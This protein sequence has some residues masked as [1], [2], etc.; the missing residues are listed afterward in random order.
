MQIEFIGP[1]ASLSLPMLA[2]VGSDFDVS[3]WDVRM[4]GVGGGGSSGVGGGVCTLW[5]A[6]RALRGHGERTEASHRTF[7]TQ[8]SYNGATTSMLLPSLAS[9]GGQLEV[10]FLKGDGA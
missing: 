8:F 1:L 6:R 3:V 7:V 2:H 4:C 10:I 9:V 5:S